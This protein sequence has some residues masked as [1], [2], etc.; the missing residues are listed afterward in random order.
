MRHAFHPPAEPR[1]VTRASHDRH[2]GNVF[3]NARNTNR[4]FTLLELIIVLVIIATLGAL[5]A[6]RIGDNVQRSRAASTRA[7]F[8]AWE[9]GIALYMSDWKEYPPEVG[10]LSQPLLLQNYISMRH[11][12]NRPSIGGYWNWNGIYDSTTGAPIAGWIP[13]GPN[14]SVTVTT[15]PPAVIAVWQR[16]DRLY[17]DGD[18]AAGQFQDLNIYGAR[19]LTHIIAK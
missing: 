10:Y 9:A 6:V 7:G 2:G 11:W 3:K 14:M 13:Y 8:T 18:L 16:F 5:A 17:D 1:A 12:S 4:G 15:A 19:H